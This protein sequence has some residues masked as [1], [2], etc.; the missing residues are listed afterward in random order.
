MS[1]AGAQRIKK[2]DRVRPSVTAK[3]LGVSTRTIKRRILDNTIPA[4]P[5][6]NGQYRLEY[7]THRNLVM[8]GLRF[9]QTR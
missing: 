3:M 1:L 8:Y 9:F 6:G 7:E 2:G 4:I 5:V